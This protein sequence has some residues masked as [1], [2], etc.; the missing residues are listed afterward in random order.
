MLHKKR[1]DLAMGLFDTIRNWLN[2]RPKIEVTTQST[3]PQP[4]Y[5]SS[6][7]QTLVMLEPVQKVE[8]PHVEE[9]EQIKEINQLVSPI[10]TSNEIIQPPIQTQT[11]LPEEKPLVISFDTPSE[12]SA[13]ADKPKRTRRSNRR[14]RS[15]KTPTDCNQVST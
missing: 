7:Q 13:P 1:L 11:A 9:V 2:V 12:V 6:N 5:V 3:E 8:S 15:T 10:E 14:R 4:D